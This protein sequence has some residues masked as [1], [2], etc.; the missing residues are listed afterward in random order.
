M[1]SLCLI[2]HRMLPPT[3]VTI[4]NGPNRERRCR[5]A[6]FSDLYSLRRKFHRNSIENGHHTQLWQAALKTVVLSRI[7]L[8]ETQRSTWPALP[9][10]KL[11]AQTGAFGKIGNGMYAQEHYQVGKPSFSAV[12]AAPRR[13]FLFSTENRPPGQPLEVTPKK[14]SLTST[15][16]DASA[17]MAKAAAAEAKCITKK[18]TTALLRRI[19]REAADPTGV[20]STKQRSMAEDFGK[21]GKETLRMELRKE[22]K[23]KGDSHQIWHVLETISCLEYE[24]SV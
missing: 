10:G 12:L 24:M 1:N 7:F 15:E 11:C 21:K 4:T 9:N 3:Q 6:H 23:S 19:V 2:C 14:T 22:W 5:S 13:R 16:N 18:L 8:D 17:I 20:L